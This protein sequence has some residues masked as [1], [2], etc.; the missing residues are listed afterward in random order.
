VKFREAWRISKTVAVESFIKGSIQMAGG[1]TS[2]SAQQDPAKAIKRMRM[3]LNINKIVFAF[4]YGLYS[5]MIPLMLSFGGRGFDVLFATNSMFFVLALA[6]LLSFNLLYMTSFVS[7]ESLTPLAALPFSREDLSRISILSFVRMFDIPLV[8]FLITYP[9]VYWLVTASTIGA[10]IVLLL[11]VVNAVMA[12]F[13][14]FFLARGF[15]T[16]IL[17]MGGS[18]AKSALGGV[19]RLI[20]AFGTF[21]VLYLSGYLISWI[22]QLVPFFTAFERPEYSWVTLI[23]P[24]SFGYLIA[25]V[26]SSSSQSALITSLLSPGSIMVILASMVYI[27]IGY[28]AYKRGIGALR[29][30]ALGE[31]EMA[32]KMTPPSGEIRISVKGVFSAIFRKDLKLGSRNMAYTGFLFMPI[33]GVVMFTFMTSTYGVIRVTGVLAAALYSSFFMVFFALM[34]IQFEGRG[35]SVLA[36]LPISV[37]KVVQAKS[38]VPAA[39]SLTMPAALIVLSFFR[40]L[41]TFYSIVIATI[42]VGAIYAGSLIG[43]TLTCTAVGEGRLPT[44]PLQSHMGAYILAVIVSSIFTFVPIVVYGLTYLFLVQDH[45]VCVATMAIATLIDVYVSTL[46]SKAALKD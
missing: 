5:A 18:K 22:P 20:W 4:L 24:F 44:A 39:F 36:Q 43:T 33:V 12:V 28:L 40:P 13:L 8:V 11:N 7:G 38:L 3:S 30:L 6:F 1:L 37:R 19:L 25:L 15:H 26:S 10:V 29:Q 16:R 31:I 17:S 45:L 14:T 9:L 46:I 35:V 27:I 2:L 34:S 41:T 21:G 32:P 42:Q 23:Y